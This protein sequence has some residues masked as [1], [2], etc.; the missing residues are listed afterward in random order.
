VSVVCPGQVASGIV[1]SG[2]HRE[3]EAGE[4]SADATDALQEYLRSGVEAGMSPEHCAEIIFE[5][6]RMRR[7][8]IFTHP[9]FK[10]GWRE[11][12]E[13]MLAEKNPVYEV[14]DFDLL[15]EEQ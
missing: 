12:A 1:D 13:R 6:I 11:Q 7:F 2:Q 5:A 4:E 15:D 14:L 10:D 8:W 3:Y 9:H